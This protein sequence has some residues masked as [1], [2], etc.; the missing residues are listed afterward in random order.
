MLS[1]GQKWTQMRTNPRIG[2]QS[3][4]PAFWEVGT[5]HPRFAINF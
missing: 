3:M 4:R 5:H 2:R 1:E